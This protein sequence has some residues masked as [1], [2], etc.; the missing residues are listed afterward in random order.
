MEFCP[1]YVNAPSLSLICNPNLIWR[2][3]PLPPTGYTGISENEIQVGMGLIL[4]VVDLKK[5]LI[6]KQKL[7]FFLLF[8]RVKSNIVHLLRKLQGELSAHLSGHQVPE[9]S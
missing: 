5:K 9:T 4:P 6:W 7:S 1:Y 8:A 3:S 2:A